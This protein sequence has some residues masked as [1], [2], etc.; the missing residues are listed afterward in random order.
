MIK[1]G[2][3]KM[4]EGL[5]E[6]INQPIPTESVDEPKAKTKSKPKTKKTKKVAKKN[7]GLIEKVLDKKIIIS[8]DD[9]RELLN[10]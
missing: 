10:G 5:N 3:K 2:V 4:V 1:A 8:E 9:K 7:D 6:F